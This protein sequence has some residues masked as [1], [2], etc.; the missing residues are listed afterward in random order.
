VTDAATIL[1]RI[2]AE[3]HKPAREM[4]RGMYLPG[5]AVSFPTSKVPSRLIRCRSVLMADGL[6]HLDTDPNVVQL[7]PYPMETNY[8][9]TRD[10]KTPSKRKHIADVAIKFRD[11]RVIFVDYVTMREQADRPFFWRR[12][13]ERARH[14]R[15]EFDCAYSVLDERSI[16]IEPRMANLRLMWTHRQLPTEPPS[17]ALAREALRHAKLPTSIQSI[18]DSARVSRQAIRWSKDEKPVLIEETN[19]IFS[20]VMQLAMRGEVRLDLGKPLTMDSI[21]HEVTA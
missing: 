16:R 4:E 11:D 13:A 14:Y 8:W 17:L 2:F 20:A 1:K 12:K 15:E 18:S 3:G 19:L 21:V 5:H 6:V 9:S 10:E 7:S